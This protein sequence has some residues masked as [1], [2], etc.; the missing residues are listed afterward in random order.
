MVV[1][2]GAFVHCMN[3]RH[4]VSNIHEGS[5]TG[6]IGAHGVAMIASSIM[7]I[8]GISCNKFRKEQLKA[9][10]KNMQ[11]NSKSNFNMLSIGKAIKEG[12]KLSGD[13]EDLVL[14]KGS[15]KLVFHIKIMTKN[16]VIFCSYLQREHE[17]GAIM[18]STCVTISIEKAHIMTGHHDEE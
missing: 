13:Q 18:A 17:I 6:T 1:D 5:G 3:D 15:T 4:G 11:Y 16:S 12:W 2:L 10:I 14:T 7:D 9:T 8:A